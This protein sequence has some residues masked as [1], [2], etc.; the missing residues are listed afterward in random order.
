MDLVLEAD[1]TST[2]KICRPQGTN[3]RWDEGAKSLAPR[4][5]KWAQHARHARGTAVVLRRRCASGTDLTWLER[6][7]VPCEELVEYGS[8][9]RLPRPW[10]EAREAGTREGFARRRVR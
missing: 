5:A 10:L 8:G 7:L 4:T 6:G 3:V 2:E 9:H 1:T